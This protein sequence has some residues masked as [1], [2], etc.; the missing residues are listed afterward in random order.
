MQKPIISAIA[1][2]SSKNRSL[3]KDNS[4]LWKIP[5]DMKH[6]KE[7]TTGHPI[8]MGRK[9]F[10]SFGARPLPNRENI[11]ITRDTAWSAPN[12]HI[13]HSFEEALEIAKSFDP[14]EIFNIGGGQIYELGMSFTDRLYLT[15]VDTDL[16]GDTYFP[17]YSDFKKEVLR[18]DS[19]DENYKYS[20]VLF[21]K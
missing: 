4:L 2:I 19:S 3:G 13:A 18:K 6:F 10:E 8:I 17:D 14:E 7:I 16:E 21:E 5:E 20:F 1:A 9:T 12:V 11:V 15:L